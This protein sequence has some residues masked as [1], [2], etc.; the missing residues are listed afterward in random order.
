MLIAIA[1]FAMIGL[2]SNAVLSTVLTNDEVT[3]ISLLGLKPCSKALV[4]LSV[5]SPKW[6]RV[7][8]DYSKGVEVRPSSKRT[9]IS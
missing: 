2:A 3:R 8:P 9:M 6:W 5:I 1:I 7:H 4:R